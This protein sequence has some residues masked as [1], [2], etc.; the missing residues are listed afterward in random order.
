MSDTDRH[1]DSVLEQH[2]AQQL[3]ELKELR[4]DAITITQLPDNT[5]VEL[6]DE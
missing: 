3:Q 5:T 6:T 1:E 2:L 4:G